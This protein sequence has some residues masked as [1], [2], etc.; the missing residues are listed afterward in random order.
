MGVRRTSACRGYRGLRTSRTSSLAPEVA[1]P[2]SPA[3]AP[4]TTPSNPQSRLLF[5]GSCA[6]VEC[7]SPYCDSTQ[8]DVEVSGNED[9]SKKNQS[10]QK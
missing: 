6:S 4:S 9:K 8:R 2:P 3:A 5:F 1:P 7:R 10:M